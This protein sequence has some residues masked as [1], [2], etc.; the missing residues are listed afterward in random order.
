VTWLFLGVLAIVSFVAVLGFL[1]LIHELGHYSVA[2]LFGVAVERFSIGFGKPIF[3]RKAKSGTLWSIG[4]IPLGGYVKF[5]GDGGAASNPD[6]E[7]LEKI[8]TEME[9][10]GGVEAS[11]CL[12]FKPLYQR[13]LVVL[14]GPLAN[15]LLAII[16][17]AGFAFHFGTSELKAVAGELTPGFAAEQAGIQTGDVILTMNGRDATTYKKVITIV[18][19]SADTPLAVEILRDGEPMTIMVTP[20]RT[21]RKDAVGG[22]A[23]I[24]HI[25]MGFLNEESLRVHTDYGPLES[26]GYGTRETGAVIGSSL[27][28]IG[29][30]FVGREN[31]KSLG[32]IGKIAAVTGKVA[33]DTAKEDVSVKTRIY[34][35]FMRL[36]SLAAMFSIGL[37]VAN[38]M[39]IPVLDGG[40][41]LYY[42]YEAVMGRPLSAQKQEL[43]FK[44]GLS[45]LLA[46]FV[47]MTWNDIGYVQSLFS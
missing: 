22:K 14:A 29:R 7:Q 32:S 40:H 34:N 18:A 42:G 39:P 33:I 35:G 43:G 47:I 31:G 4:R 23:D 37:G 36:F 45:L 1:V 38:L 6:T 25:G 46:L 19:L 11:D 8:K 12:H 5:L 15:F 41:L 3:E 9:D 24:G 10:R 2:R 26:L 16:I 30:I 28:Y 17:F 20:R 27:R 44:I 21:E 13:V